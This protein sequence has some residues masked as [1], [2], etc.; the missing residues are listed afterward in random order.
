MKEFRNGLR[1][2]NSRG[3]CMNVQA[4]QKACSFH[5]RHLS[6][7]TLP[8]IV[9]QSEAA[10]PLLGGGWMGTLTNLLLRTLLDVSV[11]VSDTVIRLCTPDTSATLTS[12]HMQLST[13]A[14][15]W[16]AGLQVMSSLICPPS[17]AA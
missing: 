13:A 1:V 8:A 3:T 10:E 11:T 14:G 9:G 17:Q 4:K 7:L 6:S 2:T 15:D 5:H 16:K 12:Q